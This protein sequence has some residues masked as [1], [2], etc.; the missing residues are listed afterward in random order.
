M[1][2]IVFSLTILFVF[3]IN[4][5]AQTKKAIV[6]KNTVIES[7]PVVTAKL[8]NE[9]KAQKNISDLT[10]FITLT[11]EMTSMMKELFTTKFRMLDEV[12]GLAIER[13]Q[14]INKI[15]E[16]KLESTLDVK[17]F[18]SIKANTQLFKSL[19]D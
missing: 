18:E 19:T 2:K 5:S 7:Q 10:S 16:R 1:K 17:T 12:E 15:I 9:A 11:P 4:C 13:R 8:S 14:T 3:S 6:K